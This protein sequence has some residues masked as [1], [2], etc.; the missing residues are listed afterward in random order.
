MGYSECMGSMPDIADRLTL[1]KISYTDDDDIPLYY[2]DLVSMGADVTDQH[3][4][5]LCLELMNIISDDETI[6]AL[7]LQDGSPQYLLPARKSVYQE[8]AEDYPQYAKPYSIVSDGD[9]HVLRFGSDIHDYIEKSS[10][11]LDKRIDEAGD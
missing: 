8:A 6:L 3:K 2:S 1:S 5:E 9:N 10:A 4:K 11:L 7:T